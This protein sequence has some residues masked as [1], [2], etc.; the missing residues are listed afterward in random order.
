MADMPV[1]VIDAS[2]IY[3]AHRWFSSKHQDPDF[4]YR[5]SFNAG[6]DQRLFL[7][8]LHTIV[9]YD[10]IILDNSSV[11]SI[12]S[13]ID[14]FFS[15]VN[16]LAEENVLR[17][18]GIATAHAA[19]LEQVMRWVCQNLQKVSRESREYS[20]DSLKKIPVPW[21][22]H[23]SGHVDRPRMEAIASEESLDASL[24]AL[25]L[26]QYRG[27]CYA[28]Y[29]NNLALRSKIPVA[30]AAA[31]GRMRALKPVMSG[32]EISRFG[33]PRESYAAL[34]RELALPDMGYTF[35]FLDD[36]GGIDL[37]P[38]TL[39]IGDTSPR[40][41]LREAL[42]LRKNTTSEQVRLDWGEKLFA[43]RLSAAVGP[44]YTQNITNSTVIGPLTQQIVARPV[45]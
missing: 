12:G 4:A 1:A 20:I 33:Y 27:L 42:A 21:S 6:D 35:G 11:S 19:V 25:A 17:A 38:L 26:F 10:Y 43:Y 36:A 24:T 9:L 34:A 3:G 23:A 5:E 44:H 13:E 8:L 41:A 16:A 29:A 14:E 15:L 32:A 31:P 37:S 40:K 22:Y 18:E 30:Y 28:G 39:A 7:E 45:S 2:M